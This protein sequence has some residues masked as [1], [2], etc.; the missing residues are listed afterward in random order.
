VR[1]LIAD[2]HT[3]VRRGI[4]QILV[5]AFEGCEVVEAPNAAELMAHVRAE[6]WDTVVLDITLPDRNGLDVLKDLKQEKPSLPV[7][8]LSMHPEEQF[9][10]RILRGGGVGYVPKESASEE[11]THAINLG[12]KG[13]R[14]MSPALAR[15]IALESI[16]NIKDLPD[17]VE[18]S[19]REIQVLCLI[20]EGKTL[21]E[22]A[23][24][25]SLST[26]TVST[27]RARLMEKIGA[28][29]NADLIHYAITHGYVIK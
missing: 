14:Y 29:N 12:L 25:L 28:V 9:A 23:D 11:L 17:L 6:E 24:M 27:Y 3:V 2:D 22:M 26:K 18:L 5:D 13:Q 10:A 4:R 15:K 1:F 20:A 21:A 8:V 7:V 16:T 19:D